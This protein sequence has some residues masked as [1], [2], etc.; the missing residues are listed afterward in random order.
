MSA[1]RFK[2][3]WTWYSGPDAR[4]EDLR[5]FDTEEEALEYQ[6]DPK[7]RGFLGGKWVQ[8]VAVRP[9]ETPTFT[10]DPPVHYPGPETQEESQRRIRL[11]LLITRLRK[12]G[13]N[14]EKMTYVERELE[15]TD[16]ELAQA[17]AILAEEQAKKDERARQR[18]V[19]KGA[20]GHA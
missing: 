10:T 6:A 11:E 12:A 16:D 5:M 7:G 19:A 17:W 8:R 4:T 2:S 1:S 20:A 9:W 13:D 14:P 18:A 15:P 3:W